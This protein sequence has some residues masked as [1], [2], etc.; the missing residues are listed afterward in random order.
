MT[1]KITSNNISSSGTNPGIYINP[2]LNVNSSGIVTSS[3]SGSVVPLITSSVIIADAN[4][5]STQNT[6][7]NTS[8]ARLIVTGSNF[9]TAGT[10]AQLIKNSGIYTFITASSSNFLTYTLGLS[11][12]AQTNTNILTFSNTA[13]LFVGMQVYGN[14]G[15]QSETTISSI[16]NNQVTITKPIL[17]NINGGQTVTFRTYT[18]LAITFSNVPSG[19]YHL[20]LINLTGAR[21]TKINYVTFA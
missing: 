1:T 15:I 12:T 14:A 3:N 20:I 2:I 5:N 9:S 18:K 11:E 7:A 21:A 10:A 8:I 13:D 6:T 16:N 17:N 19:T 4:W